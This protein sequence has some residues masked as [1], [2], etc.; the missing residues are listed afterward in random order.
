M[1]SP[2]LLHHALLA[3]LEPSHAFRGGDLRAHRARLTV[4][5]RRALGFQHLPA[6]RTSLDPEVLWQRQMAFGRLEK[7]LFSA[8][9]LARVPAY[10]A[11]P[12]RG[13]PP[14]PVMICLQGHSSGQHVSLALDAEDETREISVAGGRDYGRQALAEGWAALCIEQR[15]LGERG[16]RHQA[17]VNRYNPCHDAALHA[18]MLGRTLLAERVYDVD[19]ALDFIA[20]RPE[21]DSS[22]VGVMGN[23]GGGTV[24]LWAGALLGRIGFVLAS[25]ALCTFRH[26]L[27]SVYH[28]A[29]NYVPGLLRIAEM[30]DVAGLVAPR[31]LLAVTGRD[32]ALFPLAGVQACHE[33]LARI[34][35]AHGASARLRLIVAEGGHQFYPEL[36]WPE[37]RRLTREAWSRA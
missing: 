33:A 20:T 12:T 29:D 18:L 24:A 5:L 26:S 13:S 6:E 3:E 30:A 37:V 7:L 31:P 2:S 34:Y 10:L 25:C 32:D 4:E 28:C 11:L 27:M 36:A 17:H 35:A 23:S 8:E 21:L 14:F 16:E 15:S 1:F 19:R 22:R 9:P